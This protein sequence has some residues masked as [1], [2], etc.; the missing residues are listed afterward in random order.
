MRF[1]PALTYYIWTPSALVGYDLIV[2]KNVLLRI[3]RNR[4]EELAVIG[5]EE[6][7]PAVREN[8]HFFALDRGCTLLP[9]LID[10]HLHLA[11]NGF[12]FNRARTSWLTESDRRQAVEK[13]FS[14]LLQAGI[15]AVRDGGDSAGLNLEARGLV[16]GK[17]VMGPQVV[18]VGQAIRGKGGYGSFLGPAFTGTGMIPGLVQDVLDSGS[19]QLKVVVSGIVSFC[20]Y[21]R[22]KGPLLSLQA[23]E[24]M[25]AEAHLRGLKV[26]AHAS[27]DEAVSRAVKAGVDSVEHGYFVGSETLAMMA[28]KQTAWLPTILPVAVQSG[29]SF[30]ALRTKMEIGVIKRT[31]LEQQEKLHIALCAGVPLGIGTD[32]GATGV[33]HG[34]SLLEE[35]LLYA[36]ALSGNNREALKAAT[37]T[38]ARIIGLEKEIGSI[39]VGKRASMIVVRG[40]PLENLAAL[41][42]I[43]THYLA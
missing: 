31:Y 13:A 15:G 39:A 36:E 3:H 10:A 20:S 4:I 30:S 29:P 6:L 23:L 34:Q 21:G 16:V 42:N 8:R 19:D 5:R 27:S 43:D 12:D 33:I 2:E 32:A 38:N 35:M 9:S 22:V 41:R 26:M 24:S 40:N 37:S 28:E 17:K 25:V 7:P 14:K 18:A 1:D 11:L